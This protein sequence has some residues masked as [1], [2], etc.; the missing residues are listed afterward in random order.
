[1]R[2][3][4]AMLLA[5]LLLAGA[6]AAQEPVSPV[7]GPPPP[8]PPEPVFDPYHAL[9]SIEIGKF[10]MKKGNYDAALDRF[11]L[12]ARYQPSLAEP[13]HLMGEVYEKKKEKAEAVKAYQKYLELYPSAPDAGKIRKRIEKLNRETQRAA[14]RHKSG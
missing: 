11:Q 2:L 3:H 1:M 12:A 4:H 6:A 14:A 7:S 9:K 10:Y 8:P 5:L 13:W